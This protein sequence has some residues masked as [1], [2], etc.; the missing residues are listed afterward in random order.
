MG[1]DIKA[2]RG[3]YR[4]ITRVAASG[5]AAFESLRIVQE[6]GVPVQVRTTVDPTVLGPDEVARLQED[7]RALG[8]TD[9]VLQ[10]VR[11]EGTTQEFTDAIDAWRRT[12]AI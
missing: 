4:D 11:T 3:L 5:E 9:H 6:A 1:L 12:Q 7:L 2:T 8:V 10:E